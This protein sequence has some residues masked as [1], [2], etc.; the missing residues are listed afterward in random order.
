M[1]KFKY[2]PLTPHQ[3]NDYRLGVADANNQLPEALTS[4]GSGLP[5]RCCLTDI[6]KDEPCLLIGHRPFPKTDP[7]A[8]TGPIFIHKNHCPSFSESGIPPII[9][10]RK[11]VLI[12]GY[13][14]N[15]RIVDG[16]G[17]VVKTQNIEE[18]FT[19]ILTHEL[20]NYLHVRSVTN[21]CYFCRVELA[22]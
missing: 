9:S 11:K 21:N 17:K 2:H 10:T 16:T 3:V 7:Y 5:C 15:N 1:M 4:D 18:E 6:E 8:E 22:I 20:V 13:A 14:R 19:Q 12:R